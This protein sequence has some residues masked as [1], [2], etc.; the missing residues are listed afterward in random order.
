MDTRW[1]EAFITVAEELHFGRAAS[2]LHMAHSPL[3]QVIRKLERE[4]G[5]ELFERSTR[6]VTMTSAG[7]AFLPYARETLERLESGRDATSVAAGQTVG[8]VRIGYSGVL[9]HVLLP[10]LTRRVHEELPGVR[11]ELIGRILTHDAEQQLGLGALDLA[12]VGLPMPANSLNTRL[13][14]R[15]HLGAV[16]PQTH[17]LAQQ[18]GPGTIDLAE[19]AEEPFVTTSMSGGSALRQTLFR[20]CADAGFMPR[21]VQET[22][23]PYVVLLLVAASVGITLMPETIAPMLPP[24]S[25]FLP[26]SAPSVPLEHGI[27]WRTRPPSPALQA[28]LDLAE[29]VIAEKV[30]R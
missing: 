15:E 5:S 19:L 16:L 2:R 6:S 29:Q 13:L 10:T 12:C 28:V 27:A 1:L 20:Q 14:Y 21:V 9:N 8:R 30:T 22:S 26:L 17:R 24:G 18:D 11:L 23:D 4:I 25:V 3:S 7:A